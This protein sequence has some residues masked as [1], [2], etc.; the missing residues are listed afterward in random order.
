MIGDSETD[1]GRC[2]HCGARFTYA[3]VHNGFNDSAFAYCDACGQTAMLG[4]WFEGIPEDAHFKAHGPI[5]S[6]CERWLAPCECGG[7]FKGDASPRC[8]RCRRELSASAARNWIE[9][10][11]PGTEKGWS[12]QGKWS[13]LYSIII[14]GHVA[15]DNWRKHTA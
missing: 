9:A 15:N 10:N 3:L 8:P 11:A 1:T 6:E 5:S 2:E 7:S 12:W 13:G 14:E 4:A